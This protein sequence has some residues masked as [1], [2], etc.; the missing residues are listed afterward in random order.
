VLVTSIASLLAAHG[1]F[2]AEAVFSSG[3]FTSDATS[4][5]SST[6]TYTAIANVIGSD[7]TVNGA[8]FIGSGAGLSGTGWELTN[9]PNNFPSGGIHQ[10]LGGAAIA[11]L[12]DGFQY[13][14][15][16]GTLTLSG[17]TAGRAYVATLY[18]Q[19]WT[20]P[21]DRTNTF[22]SSEGASTLYNSDALAASVLRYTFV[23]TGDTT[24]LNF[25]QTRGNYSLHVYGL[26]NEQVFVNTWSPGGANSY[27]NAANWSGGVVPANAAGSSAS[28]SAQAGPTTVT[29]PAVRTVGHIEILGTGSYTLTNNEG[30]LKLQADAGGVSVLKTEAGGSHT[31][32]GSI[33]LLSDVIKVG[34]G[35]LTLARDVSGDKSVTVGGGTLRFGVENTYSRG[36]T[37]GAGATLDLNGTNQLFFNGLS[38]GSGLSGA[39]TIVNDNS[40]TSV[41][42][43]ESGQFS[44]SIRDHNV[45]TGIVAL[46]KTSGGTLTLS[47]SNTYTGPTTINAGTLKLEGTASTAL[48]TDN[49]LA[50]NTTNT[51]DLNANIT[52][53]QTGTAAFQSW[54]AAGN[55]QVGNPRSSSSPREP[56]GT[57]FCSPLARAPR[58][59]ACPSIPQMSRPPQGELRHV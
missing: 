6:K 1:G 45:G 54:T 37:V 7:V 43:I 29:L 52:N 34:G 40:G 27:N 12:F 20:L 18:N 33:Q 5:V 21:D 50:P 55:T 59:M 49:F 2:A 36:T 9:L 56:M 17:L 46:T 14:G 44:G 28:F 8:T 58:S 31:I 39:G 47:G 53:R 15:D 24:T 25:A 38:G 22:T 23:A 57:I 32:D 10:S 41:A 4:G 30:L 19:A 13:G 51:F 35:T 26:S 3:A 16:P 42:T 48:L 11:N